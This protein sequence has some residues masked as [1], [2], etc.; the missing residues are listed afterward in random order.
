MFFYIMKR[1][2]M[3]ICVTVVTFSLLFFCYF[4]SSPDAILLFSIFVL[5]SSTPECLHLFTIT[6]TPMYVCEAHF[7]VHIYD[8]KLYAPDVFI[9]H[10]VKA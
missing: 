5:S 7:N 10:D 3:D 8:F 4:F 2:K 9:F 6:H 1:E